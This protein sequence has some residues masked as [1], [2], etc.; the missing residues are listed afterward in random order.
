MRNAEFWKPIGGQLGHGERVD[1]GHH[2]AR[3]AWEAQRRLGKGRVA[4]L[5]TLESDHPI[6]DPAYAPFESSRYCVIIEQGE[7]GA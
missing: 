3:A 5:R 1:G 2:T 4:C 7:E 6:E